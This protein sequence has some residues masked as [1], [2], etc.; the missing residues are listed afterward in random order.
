M[1][2]MMFAMLA[3]ML[4]VCV[5][6]QRYAIDFYAPGAGADLQ[7]VYLLNAE[8]NSLIDSF[9]VSHERAHLE[10]NYAA[11]PVLATIAPTRYMRGGYVTFILDSENTS[12]EFDAAKRSQQ[13]P[14]GGASIKGSAQNQ[15]LA[16]VV[17]SFSAHIAVLQKLSADLRAAI[18]EGGQPTE[19]QI[20]EYRQ[21]AGAE[22]EAI[23][24]DFQQ[25]MQTERANKVSLYCLMQASDIFD[26]E[27]LSNYLEGYAFAD[28][29][30]LK[31]LQAQL[32]SAKLRAPG[33]PF[34]DFEMADQA[35]TMHKLSDFVG[36]GKYV[37]VDFWASWCGPCRQEMPN[38]KAAYEHFHD[39]GFDIV[40]VS[41]DNNRDAWLKGIADL[42]MTWTQLSDLQGWNCAAGQLYKIH[43]IPCTILFGP[44]GKVV[45][46]DLRGEA[47]AKMLEEKLP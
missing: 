19:A 7:K 23:K 29:P 10:G 14:L 22:E 9:A 21:K 17:D 24:T 5:Y 47:L 37:M 42:G 41:F 46:S 45:A 32:E 44:D 15:R 38:V 16:A 27:Y 2:K 30:A 6:A 34:I 35:G 33:A 20:N 18:P 31:R 40:A 13:N 28:S 4:S 36:K 12:V 11:L 8:T 25:A 1:K 26:T 43:A 39:K 3:A